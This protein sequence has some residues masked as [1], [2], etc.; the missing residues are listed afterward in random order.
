MKLPRYVH[1]GIFP[2]DS[3]VE[4]GGMLVHP[5]EAKSS[6]SDVA[7]LE[8]MQLAIEK[9]TNLLYTYAAEADAL[10]IKLHDILQRL[11]EDA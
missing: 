7:E 6:D 3:W 11:E 4:L 8:L 5:A 9:L 2:K 1:T 10:A